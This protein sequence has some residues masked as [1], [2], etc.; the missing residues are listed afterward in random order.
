MRV[1]E[2]IGVRCP[3][4]TSQFRN[5]TWAPNPLCHGNPQYPAPIAFAPRPAFAML[6]SEQNASPAHRER[7]LWMASRHP[8]PVEIIS[9]VRPSRYFLIPHLAR[10][11]ATRTTA[12]LGN[13]CLGDYHASHT[14]LRDTSPRLS[15]RCC[16]RSQK[17]PKAVNS[18]MMDGWMDGRMDG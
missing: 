2:E 17:P 4:T 9:V 6:P 12:Q 16:A 13:I 1:R 8:L 5:W 11:W 15:A 3:I 7:R 10:L 18:C 14:W